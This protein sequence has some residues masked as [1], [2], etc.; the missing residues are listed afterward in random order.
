MNIFVI[1]TTL[2]A[3]G[4]ITI[5]KQFLSH[6]PKYIG[7]DK[8]WI[9][10]NPILPQVVIEGVEYISFPLQSKMK[11]IL[12]E[13]KLLQREITKLR[14]KP[15]ILVSLQNN[16]YKEIKGCKQIVYYHQPMP[17][18]PGVWNPFKSQERSQFLYK[19]IFPH[20]VKRTWAKNIQFVVQI[21]FI[22][23]RMV[24][25]FG[26]PERNIHLCFPDVERID[27]EN[28]KPYAFKNN[29]YHFLC[30]VVGDVPRYKN[31]LTLI[32][33]AVILKRNYKETYKSVE[34]HLTTTAGDACVWAAEVK[35]YGVEDII[36]F[37]GKYK[38]DEL[39]G[40]YKNADALLFPSYIETLGLPLLE[41]AAFGLPVLAADVDYAHEVLKDYEG[42]RYIDVFD[43]EGWARNI[44]EFGMNKK[45]YR[46]LP[47][48][49]ESD[50]GRFF[51][52]IKSAK[53]E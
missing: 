42:V 43:Y 5:Y 4:G 47:Q 14:V 19:Y 52:L 6:L 40:L 20:I 27:V 28:V 53:Y 15:D 22:K 9:F 16:G 38:H 46:P 37:D 50:W 32:R 35:K 33:A 29:A 23:R 1:A 34:I 18:Y 36:K 41:A 3:G 11:R 7:H 48:N 49:R 13:G 51:D 44:I 21:P 30:V 10:V 39:L 17:L 25:F 12:F 26:I 24:E 31:L 45:R 2:Q 8:Y